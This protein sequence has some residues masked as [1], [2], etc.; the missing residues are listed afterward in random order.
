MKK[1]INLMVRD[2]VAVAD[3]TLYIC[4]NSDFSLEIDFDAEWNEFPTK[5]ARFVYGGEY[6]DVVFQGNVCPVPVLSNV[7]RF[8]VGVFAGNLRTTT[9]AYVSAQRSI[10]C[11]SGAPA[12]P[13][14]DVYNQ[15]MELLNQAG[16]GGV[17]LPYVTE[18]DDGK[19]LMVAGGKWKAEELP[20]YDG[21]YEVTP[22][23]EADVNLQTANT[24]MDANVVVQKIPFAEVK[25]TANGV[26]ATIG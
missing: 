6:Q 17:S 19:V 10:L 16:G 14:D 13:P 4:G 1:T 9:P 5:T 15:I 11:G 24:Y 3:N 23:T 21:T 25:N 20:T 7:H 2:K 26:T 22:S 18:A 12:A 8:Y